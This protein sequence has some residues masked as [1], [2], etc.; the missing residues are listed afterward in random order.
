MNKIVAL[1]LAGALVLSVTA[2]VVAADAPATLKGRIVK[3]DGANVTVKTG[4][5]DTAKEVVVV[6]DDKTVVTIDGAAKTVADLKEKMRVVVTPAT[7]TATKIEA[8]T[9]G[10]GGGHKGGTQ[11]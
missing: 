2:I 11:G 6:T 1:L 9:P 10:A 8:K 4:H 5:G 3:V 7:G